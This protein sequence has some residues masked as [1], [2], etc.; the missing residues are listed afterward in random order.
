LLSLQNGITATLGQATIPA[1][2]YSALR[3]II[4]PSKSS[5]TLKNGMVLTSSSSPSVSFPSA[6]QSGIKVILSQPVQIVAGTT[7]SLLVDFDVNSS[8]VQR[9]NTID[10]SGLLFKPV[11][12]GSIT[13]LATTSAMVRLFNATN[14]ALTL[15]QNG[16]AATGGSALAFGTASSCLTVPVSGSTLTVTQAGSSTA[17]TGFAPTLTAGSNATFIAYPTA[18]GGVQFATLGNAFTPTAG[19]AG[20]RVFNATSATTGYDAFVTAL[21]AALGTATVTNVL[22][23]G[24]SAFASVPAGSQQIRLTST[25]STALLLDAGA[26]TLTAGQNYT[27]VVEPPAAGSTTPRVALIS[28][29]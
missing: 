22:A 10:K 11:I 28:G 15:N 19:S 14:N 17:L 5:V 27:L 3:L 12:K 2:S 25:G 6:A 7:T 18:T 16:T 29:C 24:S 1:G 20:L 13:N 9:G 4:D 23:G 26:M 21:G 8:F